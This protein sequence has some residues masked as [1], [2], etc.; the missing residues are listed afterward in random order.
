MAIPR[1]SH[2]TDSLLKP[3]EGAGAGEGHTV[4]AADGARQAVVLEG[5]LKDTEGEVLAGA[6]QAFAAQQVARGEVRDGQGIAV[7]MISE[8]ELALVIGTPE[9]IG[10]IRSGQ[11]GSFSLEVMTAPSA[12]DQTVPIQ[13]RVHGADRRQTDSQTQALDLLANLRSTPAGVLSAKLNDPGL[14]RFAQAVCLAVSSPCAIG[15]TPKAQV[16]ASL[17]KPL[18]RPSRY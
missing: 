17:I 13:D 8:H 9:I 3:K 11:A 1:R 2:H 14:Q 5:S 6:L 12:A 15:H 18:P 7:A 4:V 16:L 10:L